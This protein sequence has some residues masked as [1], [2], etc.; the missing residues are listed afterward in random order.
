MA[1]GTVVYLSFLQAIRDAIPKRYQ[2]AAVE[3]IVRYG[4]TGEEPDLTK[5]PA[6]MGP[7]WTLIRPQLDANNKKRQ[8]GKLGGRPPKKQKKPMVSDVETYG[9]PKEKDKVLLLSFDKSN[10]ASDGDRPEGEAGPPPSAAP[11]SADEIQELKNKLKQ[12]GARG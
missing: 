5:F 9:K 10:S 3:A 4:A 2:F 6:A 8:A 11:P 7:L 1:D 12:R